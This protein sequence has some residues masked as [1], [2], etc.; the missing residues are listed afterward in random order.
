MMRIPRTRAGGIALAFVAASISGV[1]IFVNA[2]Y[3]G[4]AGDATVYTTAKNGVAALVLLLVLVARRR[5][6]RRT[7]RARHPAR[8]AG[9]AVI[10]GSVPF[11]L[12]FEGLARAHDAARAGF[13]HKTLV[14]WVALLAVP[15]LRE[16]F[17]ALHGIAIAALIAGQVAL[18]DDLVS[19]RP[20]EGEL[21]VLA[22]TL[23][24]AV[25]FVVAKRL[26]S[27]VGSLELGAARLGLGLVLLL[28]YVFASGRADALA[29]LTGR[30]W[31]W[32]AA[33]G[34]ILAA[35]VSS[36]FA[37]LSRAQA[38]DVT[39]VLVFGQVVTA[40]LSSTVTGT[41]L[42]VAGLGLISVGVAAAVL[43]STRARAPLAGASG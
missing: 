42:P 25:E 6:G 4:A 34:V 18:V 5:S 43:G 14:L 38:I 41:A 10:G 20:G 2:E 26:L 19:L 13:I 8:I 11:V 40:A 1:A 7:A 24:W 30:Q 16:R 37:A 36:W 27:S 22:A 28:A 29:S 35:F 17:S 39:A 9:L 33:T 12:F 21:M 23:L 31:A 32:A 15:L 3:V